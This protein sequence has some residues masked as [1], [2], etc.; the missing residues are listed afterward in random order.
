MNSRK[1]SVLP[2]NKGRKNY[3]DLIRSLPI[4][5]NQIV[6]GF[7]GSGELSRVIREIHSCPKAI[8]AEKFDPL[9]TYYEEK[10]TLTE[11]HINF[12]AYVVDTNGK[13]D[14]SALKRVWQYCREVISDKP[15]AK[16][17]FPLS[18]AQSLAILLECGYTHSIRF[19]KKGHNIPVDKKKA[20][21]AI[22]NGLRSP[23]V[24][25]PDRVFSDWTEAIAAGNPHEAIFTADPPYYNAAQVY[26][27]DS[28]SACGLPPIRKAM[29]LGYKQ[30]FAFNNFDLFFNTDIIALSKKHEYELISGSTNHV[31]RIDNK[32]KAK[33]IG[34]TSL[35]DSV[36]GVF[37]DGPSG[38]WYWFLN[39]KI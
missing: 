5:C 35:F 1:Q 12:C 34:S 33:K 19:S 13:V 10:V 9:R 36:P 25:Q 37:E 4:E 30:I 32:N 27:H 29:E 6:E 31:Y 2:G 17:I 11:V 24:F 18:K 7:L 22:K 21:S 38:E 14:E 20:E 15:L 8:G 3:H 16:E 28:P 26:Q 23:I 39:K